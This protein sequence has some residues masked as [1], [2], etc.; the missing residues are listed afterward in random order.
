MVA[1][2]QSQFSVIMNNFL[3]TISESDTLSHLHMKA[4]AFRKFSKGVLLQSP[5]FNLDIVFVFV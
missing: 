2:P 5:T 4:K 3:I 1:L